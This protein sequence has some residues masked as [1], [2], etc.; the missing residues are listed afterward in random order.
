M[1]IQTINHAFDRAI[2]TTDVGQNQLWATQ[3][4]TL[5]M[6]RQL[7][8]SGGLGTMGYGLPAAIGAKIGNPDT[9]VIVIAGDGGIQ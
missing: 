7:L 3:F 9:D 8:T 2:I 5:N 1:I 4:L 6:H